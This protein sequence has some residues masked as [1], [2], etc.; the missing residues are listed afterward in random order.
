M[1]GRRAA[2]RW[3]AVLLVGVILVAP[4]QAKDKEKGGFSTGFVRWRSAENAFEGWARSG[5]KLGEGGTLQMDMQTATPG[6]DPYP[7]G[8]YYGH[9]FYNGGSFCAGEA[10]SP[11]ISTGTAFTEAIASWNADTPAGTWLETELRA[12]VGDHWTKWYNMGV[13]AS[14]S[15]TIERHSVN[16]QGDNDGYVAVDTLVLSDKAPAATKL[17]LKV[18]LFSADGSATPTLRNASVAFSTAAE[19]PKALEPAGDVRDV[20][21]GVPE[22]SQMVYPDGGNVWCSP[23]S[24]SMVLGFWGQS[25]DSCSDRVHAAV[26]GVYDW[27]YDGHGNWPFNTAYAATYGLEA[28]VARFSSLRQLEPW[29]AAGVPVVM[30]DAWKKNELTGAPVKSSSGHLVVLAGFD[31]NG[32]PVVN[33]PAAA[34]DDEVQ[35]TYDRTEF[36]TIWLEHSAGTVYLIY[37]PTVKA[38]QLPQ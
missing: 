38:P 12:Y 8:T 32:N 3:L 27:L 6:S 4:V 20:V 14:D 35:R 15:S 9:N 1:A 13:W 5:V 10:T 19:K 7:A 17:Q 28:Y 21:L 2:A 36:E 29:I 22:C 37:P 25:G 23:T 33:D 30:S 26:A 24:T 34:T 31:A 16:L 11:E 18:R